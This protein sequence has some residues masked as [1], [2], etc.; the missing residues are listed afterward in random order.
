MARTKKTNAILP[1]LNLKD[2][3]SSENDDSISSELEK[4]SDEELISSEADS[5]DGV[6]NAQDTGN[7]D[8]STDDEDTSDSQKYAERIVES[9]SDE[10]HS[11]QAE[12]SDHATS[13]PVYR[14]YPTVRKSP[15]EA[16]IMRDVELMVASGSK[17]SRV[18][19]YIR[20]HTPHE[21]QMQDV[22]N[23][24]EKLKRTGKLGSSWEYN[25]QRCTF[26]VMAQ[27]GNGQAEQHSVIE[28]NADWHMVKVVKH[29]Q[30][31]NDWERTKVIMVDK[32]MNE[33]DVL[34]S[35]FPYARI[36]LCH[37]HVIKWLRN[38]VRNEK[39]YGTYS[40]DELKQLDF[41]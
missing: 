21:V 24:F 41:V 27:F 36:L 30:S 18:Y 31:V 28:S 12:G 32:D 9:G 11:S 6:P 5:D 8:G 13:E 23:M 25:Y 4:L 34:K 16:P 7:I 38:A 19:D 39:M 15:E 20:T 3:D 14:G 40:S 17:P 10:D 1:A 35:M 37:F 29:F 33:I 2:D 26:M 22:Y